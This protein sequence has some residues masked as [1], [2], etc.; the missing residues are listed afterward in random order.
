VLVWSA[1][2]PNFSMNVHKLNRRDYAGERRARAA[3]KAARV[4]AKLRR[5]AAVAAALRCGSTIRVEDA[6]AGLR[7]VLGRAPRLADGDYA[8]AVKRLLACAHVRPLEAWE[9]RGKGREALFRSLA[10]HLLATFP[11]SPMLWSVFFD[12]GVAPLVP[13]VVS[14]AVGGSFGDAARDPSFPIPLPRRICHVILSD[15]T[16]GTLLRA[17]R[18]A[19][20]LAAGGDLRLYDR[21][22]RTAHAQKIGTRGDEAF[23]LTVLVWLAKT[24][25][26][27]NDLGPTLDYVAHRRAHDA[28]FSMTGRSA[29]ALRRGRNEWHRD[30]A[31]ARLT[32]YVV[33][34]PSGFRAMTFDLS[35]RGHDGARHKRIWR[36]EEI[37]DTKTLLDEGRRM[38]HCVYSYAGA[39]ERRMTSIWTMT[40]ED[41]QGPTGRWSML[42]VE[43]AN[44]ARRVV[45]ARGRFNRQATSAE[46]TLLLRWAGPNGLTITC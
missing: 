16:S 44:G 28:S 20:V 5:E 13:V 10:D 32:R 43:V 1:T 35:E 11:T 45:Q 8:A 30:L 40:F 25:L 26:A 39:V 27:E 23:W 33:F 42:T 24:P 46:R 21:W 17:I 9:P 38:G 34:E 6:D 7:L 2:T 3:E 19:Q 22:M 36:V 4:E 12:A 41:G 15:R 14:I 37:R 29:A 31:R 18:R